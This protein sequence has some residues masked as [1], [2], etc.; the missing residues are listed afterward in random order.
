MVELAQANPVAQRSFRAGP[1]RLAEALAIAVAISLP[2]S[3][4]AT[5]ILLVGWVLIIVWALRPAAVAAAAFT[6]AGG[7]PILLWALAAGGMLWTHASWS[8]RLAGLG[9]YTKL[10][11]IPLL[12]AQFRHSARGLTVLQAFLASA[13]VLMLLAWVHGLWHGRSWLP[14]MTQQDGVP[15]KD[16][17]TQSE[18]FEI[19]SFV[20]IYL[21]LD[22]VRVRLWLKAV[23]WTALG[24]LFFANII[25]L[26]ASRTTLL[27]MP[28]LA[29]LLGFRRLRWQ[30]V[31]ICAA[32]GAFVAGIAWAASPYL[33]D[34]VTAVTTELSQYQQHHAETSSGTRLE[35]WTKSLGFVAEAPVFGHGTGSIRELFRRAATGQNGVGAIVSSNPHQQTLAI[36]IELGV[37]GIGVLLAMWGAHLA[38]FRGWGVV[39]WC[40]SVVVVQNIVASQFNSHLFDFTQGLALCRW[41]GGRGRTGACS[42]TPLRAARLIGSCSSLPGR[43][44]VAVLPDNNDLGR[45]HRQQPIQCQSDAN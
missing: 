16:Y 45:R 38:L 4:T 35:F 14:T 5:S 28:V 43:G 8:E 23:G 32:L 33:R 15:V 39:R 22:Y 36:G 30:G 3:T 9:P 26:A 18:I 27:I 11:V 17:I 29:L 6:A 2:W 42:R 1:V 20:S 40:G 13:F 19:C 34:R 24:L 10:L 21:A 41:G 31:A 7:L 37:L 12:L 25:S 44:R